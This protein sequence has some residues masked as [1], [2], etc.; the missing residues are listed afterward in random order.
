MNATPR[1][2]AAFLPILLLATAAPVLA[3]ENTLTAD[4]KGRPRRFGGKDAEPDERGYSDHFPA[5][6]R[7]KVQGK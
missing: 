1:L 4:R 6:V 5:T 7:L 3:A 2:H